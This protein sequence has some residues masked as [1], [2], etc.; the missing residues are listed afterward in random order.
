MDKKE[1]DVMVNMD[2]D[3]FGEM[4]LAEYSESSSCETCTVHLNHSQQEQLMERCQTI[5]DFME[6]QFGNIDNFFDWDY[7]LKIAGEQI[8]EEGFEFCVFVDD[9]TG[10]GFF[11]TAENFLTE[12]E[13][14]KLLD[15]CYELK[16]DYNSEGAVA[17]K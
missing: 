17:P 9:G 4:I 8:A 3:L 2:E 13:Y 1:I 5:R 6:E 10:M 7:N 11:V 14:K 16:A 15:L 12:A